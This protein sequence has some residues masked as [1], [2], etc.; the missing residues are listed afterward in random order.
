M[1]PTSPPPK[2]L[3]LIGASRGLGCAMTG[4]F[5]RRGWNVVGTT[6]GSRRTPLHEL[7]QRFPGRIEI[8]SVDITM[9]EQIAALRSRLAGRTF[10]M[11]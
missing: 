3:L 1:S 10:D 4:E 11:L 8:E 7:S 9:R 5:V 2:T 6:R